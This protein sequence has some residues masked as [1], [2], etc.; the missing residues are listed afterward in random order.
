[1]IG[2][3]SPSNLNPQTSNHIQTSAPPHRQASCYVVVENGEERVLVV[4]NAKFSSFVST[5]YSLLNCVSY[6][7]DSTN[8]LF[9]KDI[10][11]VIE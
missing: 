1:V 2:D 7:R 3:R 10:E 5:R 6:P 11:E 4:Q 9:M 8:V